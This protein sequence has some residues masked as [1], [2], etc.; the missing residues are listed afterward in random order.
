MTAPEIGWDG[1][2]RCRCSTSLSR[3][4]G[5]QCQSRIRNNLINQAAFLFNER[6]FHAVALDRFPLKLAASLGEALMTAR[7]ASR[8]LS[9]SALSSTLRPASASLR[10]QIMVGTRH[11]EMKLLQT[12]VS[13]SDPG[14]TRRDRSNI[15]V[16]RFLD[17]A[18][19][20]REGAR[21]ASNV[22]AHASHPLSRLFACFARPIP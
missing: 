1:L 9:N 20:D 2:R 14:P 3:G 6:V 11:W 19:P 16:A 13:T 7:P 18:M 22:G 5:R 10:I 8:R 21:P 17:H 15:A 12:S 4:T